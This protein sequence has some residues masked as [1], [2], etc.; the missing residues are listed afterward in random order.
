M[1]FDVDM[2][3]DC[4]TILTELCRRAG[5]DLRHEM[6]KNDKIDV[7]LQEGYQSRFAFKIVNS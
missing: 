5:W 2:L 7:Q 4:D 3:G 6:V 1:D